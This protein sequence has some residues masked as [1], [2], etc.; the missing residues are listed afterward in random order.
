MTLY[1]DN[2][3]VNRTATIKKWVILNTDLSIH[4]GCL[5]PTMKIRR[6]AVMETHSAV[7]ENVYAA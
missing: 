2:H 7:I 1:N 6:R 4:D 3:A 5:T